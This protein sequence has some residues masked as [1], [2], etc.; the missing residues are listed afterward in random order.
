MCGI[1]LFR[2]LHDNPSVL[3]LNRGQGIQ[4]F[5]MDPV[6]YST[7][8]YTPDQFLYVAHEDFAMMNVLPDEVGR[9]WIQVGEDKLSILSFFDWEYPS[10]SGWNPIAQMTIQDQGFGVEE[11]AL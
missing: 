6:E 10:S 4:V 5:E 8:S 3:T 9:L 2:N 7:Y 1:F 11:K